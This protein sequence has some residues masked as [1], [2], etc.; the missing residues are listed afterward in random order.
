M[1][2]QNSYGTLEGAQNT[3]SA[4]YK[5]RG[6]S[7]AALVLSII[8][9]LCCCVYWLGLFTGA[10]AIV[11]AVISRKT[12]GY[13]DG[14]SVAAI[15]VSIFGVVFSAVMTYITLVVMS[16]PEFIDMLKRE[17]ES[18]GVDLSGTLLRLFI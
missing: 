5:T 12:L 11:C 18:Q 14:L 9:V 1:E 13:F 10:F 2:Q 15:I 4:V 8:S 17:L 16:D 7:V 3:E 6:W